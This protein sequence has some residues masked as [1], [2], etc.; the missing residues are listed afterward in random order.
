MFWIDFFNISQSM[1][2]IKFCVLTQMVILIF[3]PWI[4]FWYMIFPD[5]GSNLGFHFLIVFDRDT[6]WWSFISFWKFS[7]RLLWYIADFYSTNGKRPEHIPSHL[8]GDTM[9]PTWIARS[10]GSISCTYLWRSTFYP[11]AGNYQFIS[12]IH[13]VLQNFVCY[14]QMEIC[15]FVLQI[16]RF[17]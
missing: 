17:C 13:K 7:C 3:R 11:S 8:Y 5:W 6:C 14:Q 1:H 16:C 2:E 10:S 12:S 15:S 4:W 9:L